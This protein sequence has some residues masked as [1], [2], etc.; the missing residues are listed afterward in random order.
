MPVKLLAA[1]ASSSQLNLSWNA[2]TPPANCSVSYNV[3]ESTTA[4]FTPSAS[5]RIATGVSSPAFQATGLKSA[6]IY[7]FVVTS[8]DAEGESAGSTPAAGTTAA[9]SCTTAPPPPTSLFATANSSSQISLMWNGVSAPS[10]CT[11]G[12]NV[13]GSTVS[14]F[15]PSSS[16]RLGSV[17]GTSDII[18]GL[19]ASTTEYFIVRAAD[20]D[21]ESSNSNQGFATTPGL[22][23]GGSSACHVTYLVNTQWPGGFNVSLSIQNTGTTAVKGW[24]LGWTW[25]SAQQLAGAWNA[26]A[27]QQGENVTFVNASWNPTIA[28]GATLSGVGF[29]GSFSTSN[30]PPTAFF[31]N[32]TRCQ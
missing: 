32:G 26:V 28:P 13:Y 6:T 10:G 24:T 15:T 4:G 8:V 3:Y 23:T 16:N 18:T 19:S 5:N 31:L 9:P 17:N 30:P 12:Y 2:V 27:T 7:D 1:T 29:N 20:A 22:P 21:G 11:V 25:P 14:G